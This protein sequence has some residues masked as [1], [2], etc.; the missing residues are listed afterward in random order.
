[1]RKRSPSTAMT[2]RTAATWLAMIVG[3]SFS[4][5]PQATEALAAGESGAIV[6]NNFATEL[7][8]IQAPQTQAHKQYKFTNPRDGWVFFSSGGPV[9][10][11]GRVLLVVGARM[12]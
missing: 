11:G 10:G 4:G 9:T 6:L 8:N 7:L 12:G 1:M 3:L 2:A 5:L